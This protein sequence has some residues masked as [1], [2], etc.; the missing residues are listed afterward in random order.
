MKDRIPT[1]WQ[2]ITISMLMEGWELIITEW[3]ISAQQIMAEDAKKN[4]RK[5]PSPERIYWRRYNPEYKLYPYDTM[6]CG[7]P[8]RKRYAMSHLE[9]YGWVL[10]SNTGWTVTDEGR[11]AKS[12][13]DE[14]FK[15]ATK[16][17]TN[18]NS[19]HSG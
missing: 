16:E 15:N 7:S 18:A 13:Y 11:A 12:R 9:R 6:G 2:A 4:K 19:H 14:W 17:L 10:K 1:Y 5:P 8:K 3:C